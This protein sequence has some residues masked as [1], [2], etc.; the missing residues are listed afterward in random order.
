MRYDVG[1]P[2][3]LGRQPRPWFPGRLSTPFFG[4]QDAVSWLHVAQR[5]RSAG[6]PS[7]LVKREKA[8]PAPPRVTKPPS[9]SSS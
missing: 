4:G 8:P 7:V 6:V 5:W 2:P 3:V 9:S 1:R